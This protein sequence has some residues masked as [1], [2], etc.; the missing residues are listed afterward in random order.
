[1][2]EWNYTRVESKEEVPVGEYRIRIYDAEKMISKNTGRE[3]IKLTFEVSGFAYAKLYH[4]VVFLDD[5]PQ[6]TNRNLTQIY[7]CFNIP[8]GNF[9]LKSWIGKV[10][11]C[12][13]KHDDEGY[14]K[15]QYFLTRKQQEMLPPWEDPNEVNSADI[16]VSDDDL[17]F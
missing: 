13:V 9:V 4:Y 8:E 17:P 15:V 7:D 6:V 3:M 2:S 16:S 11:G 1:M 5:R 14:A 12:K 10:G